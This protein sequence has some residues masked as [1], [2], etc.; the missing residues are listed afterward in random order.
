MF[1]LGFSFILSTL[2]VYM[3]D[4]NNVWAVFVNLLWFATPIFY[5]IP[6]GNIAIINK[7]N[8]IFYFIDAGRSIVVYHKVPSFNVL[9]IIFLLGTV[10]LSAGLL[11]FEKYKN[12]FAELI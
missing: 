3:N 1:I 10:F 8:P 7:I 4:L 12:K 9:L 6:S 11:I 5:L 2:G